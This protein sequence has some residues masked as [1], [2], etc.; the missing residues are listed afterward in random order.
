MICGT[1]SI[2]HYAIFLGGDKTVQICV[3]K[4]KD[5]RVLIQKTTDFPSPLSF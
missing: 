3:K 4:K 1:R 5:M 2:R